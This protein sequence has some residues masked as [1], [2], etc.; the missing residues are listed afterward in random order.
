MNTDQ[1]P[2]GFLL[3]GGVMTMV[4]EE[5]SVFIRVHLWFLSSGWSG[6]G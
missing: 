3:R 6:S 1:A 5:G 2:A 4:R